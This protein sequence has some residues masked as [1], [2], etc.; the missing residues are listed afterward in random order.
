MVRSLVIT[1]MALAIAA[2]LSAQGKSHSRSHG[3]RVGHRQS[4]R[5]V[6]SR[7]D[8]GRRA[9]DPRARRSDRNRR[10]ADRY[11]SRNRDRQW[12]QDRTRVYTRDRDLQ[13]IR[14]RARESTRQWDRDRAGAWYGDR[15]HDRYR[16]R[17]R[18]GRYYLA[19]PF[20][21]G[22]FGF[23]G[24]RH[25]FSV[26]RIAVGTRRLWLGGGF[27]FVI[28]AWDWPVTS[29]WCWD[30]DEFAVYLDPYH[31]GWYLLYDLQLGSYVHV[32][33]VGS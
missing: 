21:Y 31:P 26:I 16:D 15:D 19:R 5:H 4:Q 8:P 10:V 27:S 12:S 17:D 33:F 28:A 3:D 24:P 30:C 18:D 20:E 14:E 23:V 7:R 29:R 2:P 32:R 25:R 1:A 11:Q 22:R 6:A 9:P 13:R